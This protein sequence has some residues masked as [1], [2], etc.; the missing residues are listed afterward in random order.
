MLLSDRNHEERLNIALDI[1]VLTLQNF[2]LPIDRSLPP[3]GAKLCQ[4]F[5]VFKIAVRPM[6]RVDAERVIHQLVE[7]FQ[8]RSFQWKDQAVFGQALG[9]VRVARSPKEREQAGTVSTVSTQIAHVNQ[10][11]RQEVLCLVVQLVQRQSLF[12]VR[13]GFRPTAKSAA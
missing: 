11:G 8:V 6:V 10:Q 2:L 7:G 3:F 1:L 12:Q 4:S 13:S 5:D 9:R